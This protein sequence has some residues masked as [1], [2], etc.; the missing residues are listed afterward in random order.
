MLDLKDNKGKIEDQAYKAK[1]GCQEVSDTGRAGGVAEAMKGVVQA[2]TADASDLVGKA[3]D[4]AQHLASSVSGAAVQAKDKAVEFT[5]S[6]VNKAGDIGQ[7]LTALIRRYPFQ[8]LLVA[9]GVGFLLARLMRR[10]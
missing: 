1:G 3:K 9:A 2:V 6:A 8:S 7:D 10:E 4:T 5:S